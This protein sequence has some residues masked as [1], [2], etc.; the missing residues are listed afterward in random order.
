MGGYARTKR[1]IR[2]RIRCGRIKISWYN[3]N[4][5]EAREVDASAVSDVY[6]TL[7]GSTVPV[8][9]AYPLFCELTRLLPWIGDEAMLGIHAI[10]G[11]MNGQ[12]ELVLNHRTK[13]V[14]RCPAWRLNELPKLAGQT[15]HIGQQSLTL[16]E[17][18]IKS[19]S[20][21]SPLYA[22]CVVTGHADEKDFSREVL[23][24]L[25]E[26]GIDSR[27]IC[28][29]QQSIF[30]GKEMVAGYSLLLHS[31][32]LEHSLALQQQGF[33]LYR[34]LGCG[35]FIPHKSIVAVGSINSV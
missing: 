22:H 25:T 15:I 13:L 7:H 17:G 27:F 8:D 32:P 16:G 18:K 9:H 10:R 26:K 33:G 14:V 1:A 2:H 24:L 30:D 34:K 5:A 4:P 20:R 28:G 23:Q 31:L 6:L 21:Y 11:A 12:D 3:D 35:I 19:L 29:K